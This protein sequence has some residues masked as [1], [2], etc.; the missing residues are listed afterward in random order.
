MST[1]E[2]GPTG[3]TE[4]Q[5]EPARG[6]RR[7]RPAWAVASVAA[8]VVLAGGG[9]AYWATTA[10]GGTG[11]DSAAASAAS[12]SSATAPSPGPSAPGIAPGE[13]DPSGSGVTYRS[14]GPLP[15]G[16]GTAPSF[17][18][19]GD[20]TEAEVARL[21]SALGISGAPRLSGELWQAGVVADPSGPRLQVNLKAPGTWSF[22]RYQAGGTDNCT[23]GKDTCG[24]ATLPGGGAQAPGAASVPGSDAVP[25][26]AADTAKPLSEEA[27]KKAAAPLLAAAGQNG[28][29]LDARQVQGSVRVVTADP[30]VGGLP[31]Q[32][33]QSTVSVGPDGQVVAG[34]GEL[35]APVRSAEQPVVGAQEA[36]DRLNAAS[37][38]APGT[39]TGPS[40][41]ATSVPLEPETPV[42]PGDTPPCNP[43]PRP[44]KPPRTETVGSAVL[45]LAAGTVDG[46]RGLVPAWLFEVTGTS[47]GGAART[48]VQPAA[49][50]A[51]PAPQGGRTVPGFSYSATDRKLTVHFWGGA[52]STYA[53]QARESAEAVT[54][55][56]TDTPNEAG[57]VCI[58]IAKEMSV[59]VTLEQPL[60]NRSVVDATTGKPLARQ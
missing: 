51:G 26:P 19:G 57:R 24:P 22:T 28:A 7:R 17:A 54:V 36:L 18:A 55:K 46:A 4:Q 37:G 20:V 6:A 43:D 45:G 16:P 3:G 41:C 58:L 5:T 27:A 32:G 49:R 9:T 12:R 44:M 39:G 21:A 33:W 35:K 10:Y 8:A 50:D 40:A 14:Q 48:V 15:Q 2:S 42:G 23:R 53:A 31:T 56:I 29:K 59:T 52:C 60:G 1:E 38:P 30:V 13:P 47:G 34:T 25:P 11:K